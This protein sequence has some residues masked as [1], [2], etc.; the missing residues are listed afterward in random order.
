MKLNFGQ[1]T[2]GEIW[3]ADILNV[4]PSLEHND[5]RS[6]CHLTKSFTMVTQPLSTPLIKPN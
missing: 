2:T 1:I 4:S 6:K 5:E 3:E